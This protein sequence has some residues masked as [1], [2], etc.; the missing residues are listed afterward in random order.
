M[1]ERRK[2]SAGFL[3]VSYHACAGVSLTTSDVFLTCDTTH[4]TGLRAK[5]QLKA[6][7][8]VVEN[9]S[10]CETMPRTPQSRK[11]GES[12]SPRTPIKPVGSGKDGRGLLCGLDFKISG[13]N[14]WRSL[15]TKSLETQF[16]GCWR[17]RLTLIENRLA[18]VKSAFDAL[19]PYINEA[20]ILKTVNGKQLNTMRKQ[21]RCMTFADCRLQTA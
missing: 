4:R 10:Q 19:K 21:R 3:R 9:S 12:A 8:Y 5:L 18:C 1:R 17:R 14:T 6:G 2:T 13:Q 11:F 16:V 15:K 7:V 20:R